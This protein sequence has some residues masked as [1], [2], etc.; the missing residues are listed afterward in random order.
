VVTVV[1]VG[2]FE[3]LTFAYVVVT[4]GTTLPHINTSAK[5]SVAE[6]PV[7]VTLAVPVMED[8][9][10]RAEVAD[11]LPNSLAEIFASPLTVGLVESIAALADTPEK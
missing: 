7:N 11:T 8:N 4:P 6:I 9:D 5:E 2:E 1:H 3:V 10:P